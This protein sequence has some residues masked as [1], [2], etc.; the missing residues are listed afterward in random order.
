MDK[1]ET[2][3]LLNN[4]VKY[5]TVDINN[6]ITEFPEVGSAFMNVILAIDEEYGS[7]SMSKQISAP[8][9]AL[10]P[11]TT[12]TF[13]QFGDQFIGKYLYIPGEKGWYYFDDIKEYDDINDAY[14]FNGYSNYI[15]KVASNEKT[16]SYWRKS[17]LQDFLDGKSKGAFKLFRLK[18]GDKVKI[19]KTKQGLPL[20]PSTFNST[21]IAL[22]NGQDY[23]VITQIKNNG[24]IVL[25]HEMDPSQGDY[26][27][28][29]DL[30]PYKELGFKVGDYFTSKNWVIGNWCKITEINPTDVKGFDEAGNSFSY[31]ITSVIDSFNDGYYTI[32]P[33]PTQN[34]LTSTTGVNYITAWR[35]DWKAMGLRPSPTRKASLEKLNALGLGNDGLIYLVD[36]DKRGVKK[37]K[38]TKYNLF[39]GAN[40][41]EFSEVY[42]K[43]LLIDQLTY[44]N[45]QLDKADTDYKENEKL[46][47]LL[48]IEVQ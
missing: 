42:D 45:S 48:K 14:T 16:E 7:G 23:A 6:L 34:T 41:A 40:R 35:P 17:D 24:I 12:L 38:K 29:Q 10:L 33:D 1:K 32:I 8:A 20:D 31:E 44:E 25:W 47:K 3:R 39:N 30:E 26:F 22:K 15:A 36:E 21:K 4:L 18:V 37:W 28:A 19:P 9:P 13:K 46:I 43:N 2:S 27:I 11:N 5:N